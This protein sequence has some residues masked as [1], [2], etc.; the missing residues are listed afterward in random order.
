[1][2]SVAVKRL[3]VLVLV[4]QLVRIATMQSTKKAENHRPENLPA[5]TRRLLKARNLR[6]ACPPLKKYAI[7]LA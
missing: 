2:I 7:H 3:L 1:V 4:K 5:I 6:Q